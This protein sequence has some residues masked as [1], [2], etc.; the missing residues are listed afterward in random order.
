MWLVST[1]I[2]II[3]VLLSI[4]IFTVAC[5]SSS[6][7]TIPSTGTITTTGITAASGSY[8][9]IQTAVNEAASL[10]GGNV[11][12]PAGTF[13]FVPVGHWNDLV[14]TVA[15]VMVPAGVNIIGAAPT[16]FANG[17]VEAFSTILVCPWAVPGSVENGGSDD[18]FYFYSAGAPVTA[19]PYTSSRFA[20]IML[21]GYRAIN[22]SATGLD[23]TGGVGVEMEEIMNFRIDHC[24]FNNTAAGGVWVGYYFPNDGGNY[25][26]EDCGCIDHC[27]FVCNGGAPADSSGSENGATQ[28]YGVL[29]G[30]FHNAYWD[31]NAFDTFGHYTNYTTIIENCWFSMWRHDICNEEGSA[32]IIRYCT[33]G[34]DFGFHTIDQHGIYNLVGGRALEVYNC[35]FTQCTTS[36]WGEDA[37]F[38]RGGSAIV[39]NNTCDST[40][41]AGTF[42]T[43]SHDSL[44]FQQSTTGWTPSYSASYIGICHD[45]YVWSNNIGSTTVIEQDPGYTTLGVNDFTSAPT[46]TQGIYVPYP[47]PCPLTLGS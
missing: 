8:A 9:D 3:A 47:Y 13:N 44:T 23:Q 40:Y 37:I 10:G 25:S 6:D 36:G 2:A 38:V 4:L 18:W 42:V 24:C 41:G 14:S 33:F 21:E 34:P 11:Y 16:L 39:Y 43:L 35:S 17:S 31:S 46:A 30:Q 19:A 26:T 27:N 15:L 5:S 29:L 32:A 45:V 22:A 7:V 20:N 28:E 12:I 1:K